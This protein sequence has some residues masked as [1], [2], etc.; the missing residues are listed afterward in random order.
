[1][2]LCHKS[3]KTY[4]VKLMVLP[5]CGT[6]RTET[7]PNMTAIEKEYQAEL[8]LI[9]KEYEAT[10][11]SLEKEYQV[12]MLHIQKEYEATLAALEKEYKEESTAPKNLSR[13]L[14]VIGRSS[15]SS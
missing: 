5:Y 11:Q 6:S 12:K 15:S 7:N 2:K 9:Q 13:W 10:L 4:F 8:A 14:R 1:M 3:P